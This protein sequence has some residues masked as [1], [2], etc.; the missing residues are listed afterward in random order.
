MTPEEIHELKIWF[1]LRQ[2]KEKS[3]LY[4]AC[5]VISEKSPFITNGSLDA[6]T[7][8]FQDQMGILKKLSEE[9]VISLEGLGK[10]G[11]IVFDDKRVDEIKLT[12]INPEFKTRYNRTEASRTITNNKS[13]PSLKLKP[14]ICIS[15]LGIYLKDNPSKKYE[16]RGKRFEIVKKLTKN[17][18]MRLDDITSWNGQTSTVVSKS[19]KEININFKKD[20]LIQ[21]SEPDLINQSNT[22]GYS[23]NNK[24]YILEP[25]LD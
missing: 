14:V 7:P 12:V 16:V 5:F 19:I 15:K 13:H 18:S 8:T 2:I 23:L 22:S 24:N 11:V 21:E 9:G 10:I 1:V 6:L 4:G 3:F 25:D 20:L 17:P